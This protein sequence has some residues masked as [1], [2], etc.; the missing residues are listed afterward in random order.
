MEEH[1]LKSIIEKVDKYRKVSLNLYRLKAIQKTTNW[2]SKLITYCIIVFSFLLFLVFLNIG[3]SLWLGEILGKLY[4]G[5]IV[6]SLLHLVIG[7]FLWFFVRHWI[8][9]QVNNCIVIEL[10]EPKNYV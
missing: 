10:N 4:L 1:T 5:F 8:Q 2:L 6:V 7:L 9:N 3:A